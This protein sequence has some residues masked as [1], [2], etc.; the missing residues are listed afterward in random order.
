MNRRKTIRSMKWLR[1][2]RMLVA[3]CACARVIEPAHA[4]SSAPILPAEGS[5]HAPHIVTQGDVPIVQIAPPS[6]AGVSRNDFAAFSVGRQGVVLNNAT[7]GVATRAAGDIAANPRLGGVPARVIVNEVTGTAKTNLYGL[8]EVAGAAADV[9]IANPNGIFCGGC[10]FDN[11]P[12]VVLTTGQPVYEAEDRLAAVRVARG[13]LVV[14]DSLGADTVQRLDLWA[15]RVVVDGD[16]RLQGGELRVVGG[17]SLVRNVLG[18]GAPIIE[19]VEDAGSV[20]SPSGDVLSEWTIDVTRLGGVFAGRIHMVARDGHLGVRNAGALRAGTKVPSPGEAPGR[21][22]IDAR[23]RLENSGRIDSRGLLR[24]KA[25]GVKNAARGVIRVSDVRIEGG[26]SIDNLGQINTTTMVL[27]AEDVSNHVGETDA[28]QRRERSDPLYGPKYGW[29]NTG[30]IDAQ[31]RLT[32]A[33]KRVR[34]AVGA[35]MQSGGDLRIYGNEGA[36]KSQYEAPPASLFSNTGTVFAAR[37]LEIS[38]NAI[39]QNNGHWVVGAGPVTKTHVVQYLRLADNKLFDRSDVRESMTDGV[40]AIFTPDGERLVAYERIEFDRTS[41]IDEVIASRPGRLE[42]VRDIRLRGNVYSTASEIVAGRA[43]QHEA[44]G[45]DQTIK[46]VDV[47]GHRNETN[48]GTITKTTVAKCLDRGGLCLYTEAPR[49]YDW[50]YQSVFKRG[51]GVVR[52]GGR[53]LDA[54]A[55]LDHSVGAKP[56]MEPLTEPNPSDADHE[57]GAPNVDPVLREPGQ[58]PS[59]PGESDDSKSDDTD[60][61]DGVADHGTSSGGTANGEASNGGSPSGETPPS[62]TH[63]DTRD[64]GKPSDG[65]GHSQGGNGEPPKSQDENAKP[66]VGSVVVVAEPAKPVKPGE[67]GQSGQSAF[68]DRQSDDARAVANLA[69]TADE[70]SNDTRHTVNRFASCKSLD[71]DQARG[72]DAGSSRMGYRT[73]PGDRLDVGQRPSVTRAIHALSMEHTIDVLSAPGQ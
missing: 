48:E 20:S 4:Q 59:S 24:V 54:Q 63:E 11:M 53:T 57:G 66:A 35:R 12:S 49:P 56:H 8:V 73:C 72:V 70:M 6:A 64:F 32:I 13:D 61:D 2:A 68:T 65:N 10:A 14:H 16:V 69:R 38:A 25:D 17:E 50:S 42:A 27:A 29:Q 44:L 67:A 5:P 47:D 36:W 34:N 62:P 1:V 18:T 41:Q 31:E 40:P 60:P 28:W 39:Q 26:S 22:E 51:I 45:P 55:I 46:V 37:D 23:G 15:K 9:V 43:F 71:A 58:Q 52:E 19:R 33:A 30:R 21:I 3:A 7:T